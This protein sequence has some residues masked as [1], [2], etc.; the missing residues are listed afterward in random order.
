M[1]K[2][3][4]QRDIGDFIEAAGLLEY[5]PEK[6]SKIYQGHPLRLFKRILETI[7]LCMKML[8]LIKKRMVLRL[9][10]IP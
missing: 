4:K 1:A 8:T 10:G 7:G 6:I 3:I 9:Q 5:D 2:Q